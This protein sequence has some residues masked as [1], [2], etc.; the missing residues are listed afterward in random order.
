[1]SKERRP[2]PQP[3]PRESAEDI[4]LEDLTDHPIGAALFELLFD[5]PPARKPERRRK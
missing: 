1:M 4:P 5:K 2:D 3:D